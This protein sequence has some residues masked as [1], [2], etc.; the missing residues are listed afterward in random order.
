MS[1]ERE[2]PDAA[3]ETDDRAGREDP[4]DH[5]LHEDRV[6]PDGVLEKVEQREADEAR[7]PAADDGRE[8]EGLAR[9]LD[10]VAWSL[11]SPA[12]LSSAG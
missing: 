1:D 8:L 12:L 6:D 10:S 11:P 3:G 2:T 4:Q 7:E 9:E 5:P